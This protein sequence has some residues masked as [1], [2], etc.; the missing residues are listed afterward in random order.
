[1]NNQAM[2]RFS[3]N[4]SGSERDRERR[5]VS[6]RRRAGQ[7]EAFL[8]RGCEAVLRFFDMLLALLSD[9]NVRK[10][11]RICGAVLCFI[12]FLGVI[13]AVEA[14]TLT[15]GG[16]ILSGALLFGLAFLCVFRSKT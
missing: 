13:A 1:M 9:G 11:I 8:T 5:E 10:T 6:R 3:T 14:E 7:E 12:G 4:R 16:G 2:E 15:F